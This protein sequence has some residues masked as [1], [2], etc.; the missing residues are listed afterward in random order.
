MDK[1]QKCEENKGFFR[2]NGALW[3]N[4]CGHRKTPAAHPMHQNYNG[5]MVKFFEA[6]K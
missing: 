2:M 3:C 4:V 5:G 1:C 6:S